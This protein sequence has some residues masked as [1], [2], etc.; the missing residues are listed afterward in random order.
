MTDL[1]VANVTAPNLATAERLARA[2]VEE[3][4]AACCTLVPAVRSIYRWQGAVHDDIEVL[5]VIKTRAALLDALTARVRALHPYTL[6]EVIA[7]PIAGGSE[8]YLAW[9]RAETGA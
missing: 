1:I 3:S 8:P 2:V 5:L 6:P 4:L 9:V 7:L